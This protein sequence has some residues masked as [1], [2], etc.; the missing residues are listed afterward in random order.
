MSEGERRRGADRRRRTLRSLL[1]GN[2]NP[3]RRGPRRVRDGSLSSTDWHEPQWLAVALAI[4]LLSVT[5]AVL[6]LTLVQHGALEANPLMAV[7]LSAGP[8]LFVA[9]KLAMTAGG[10]VLLTLVAKVRAF[11]RLPVS[12]VLYTVLAAYA[13]LIAYEVWLLRTIANS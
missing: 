5:D 13:A 7:F 10:V 1:T 6:T 8:D 2:F 9:F 11:G 12:V 4:L 3:R